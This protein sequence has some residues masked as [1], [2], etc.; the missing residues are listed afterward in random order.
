MTCRNIL[1]LA[2]SITAISAATLLTHAAYAQAA[3]P[4]SSVA[5]DQQSRANPGEALAADA[6]AVARARAE[7]AA[8]EPATTLADSDAEQPGADT[9]IVTGTAIRGVAPVG[10][11]TVNIDAAS[12][13]QSGIRDASSLI[14]Q[15]PQGSGFGTTLANNGGR[16]ASINLR[17]L[18]DNATLI[19]FDG[20]RVVAQNRNQLTDPNTVPFGAIQRVEVV[21]D[22]ASAIYGSDAVAGVVNYILRKPFDGAE[23]TARY[24][25][26]LYEAGALDFVAGKTWDS[27]GIVVAFSAEMNSAVTRYDIPQLRSDLRPFGGNDNRFQGTTLSAPGATG[28]LIAGTGTSTAVYGIPTGLNGR[29]PTAAELIPLRNN[30]QLY[31][32]SLDQDYYSKRKRFSALI[33]AEQDLGSAGEIT[34]TGIYNRRTNFARGQGDGAFQ[35]VAIQIPTTSPYYVTGLAAGSQRL[36]YNFRANNPERPLNREDSFDSGNVFLDYRVPLFGDFRLSVSAVGGISEGCEVCQPQANTILTSTIAQAATA[37]LFNPYM[38][39]PQPSAE[40]LFGVFIQNS[41]HVFYNLV[42]KIDGSLFSLPAGDVRIAVG[43]EYAASEYHHRSLYSLNPTTTVVPFR[44][45]DNGRNVISAFGEVFLPVFGADNEIPLFHRLDL[46]AAVRYDRYSDFGETVNPK[47]GISWRPFEDLLLRG[48]YGTSFRAPTLSE[49]DFNV[50]GAANRTAVNNGLA[51]PSI[52]V[53]LVNNQSLILVSSF[54]FN[55]LQPETAKIFS[56]GADYSPSFIEGLK[57]GVTYYNVNYT[58]RISDLP[59]AN[60]ALSSTSAF[61][62]YSPFF[63]PA[64]QPSTCVNGSANGNPG[65][66]QYSTYNPLYLPYLNAAGSFPPTTQSDCNLVG[67][68]DS[69]TRNLGSVKQSGLDFTLNLSRDVSIGTV[70]FDGSFTKVLNLDRSLLPGLPMVSALDVIGQQVSERGRFSLGLKSGPFS[71]NVAANYIGSYLNDQTPTVSG[72][73]L[74]NQ[75]VPSWTTFDLNL[76]FSPQTEDGLFSGTRFTVSARNVT[77]D[78]PPV[79]LTSVPTAADI[80]V[81]N[82][83]GRIITLEISKEF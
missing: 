4:D 18:G 2:S 31:D 37:S 41:K 50:V 13:V 29:V 54:R 53:T 66:P 64:P 1:R 25:S 76:S 40:K 15:L 28:A 22:G 63:T 7:A 9:I 32:G 51:N 72:T 20:H 3:A 68:L 69:S 47:F 57:L 21:T 77:D 80:N 44:T 46:N 30:P 17:G 52:P 43:A 71:G 33:R 70:S 16:S 12:I 10:S 83:F 42:P 36:L 60:T 56:L 8:Q 35:S 75:Q 58:D 26:T 27:G 5:R 79:V 73:K 82:V 24:T 62:L 11:A 6:D 48:S 39:G 45:A 67:I 19:L 55:Q 59:A 23:V 61:A 74:P 49:T 34:L 14:S 38:Q 78:D 65:T 81:H